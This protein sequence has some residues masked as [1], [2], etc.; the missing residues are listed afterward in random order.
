MSDAGLMIYS[1][2]FI[3][4]YMPAGEFGRLRS[5]VNCTNVVTSYMLA[6]DPTHCFIW[7]TGMAMSLDAGFLLPWLLELSQ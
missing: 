5:A 1:K 3:F 7:A 6:I 4:I 2:A